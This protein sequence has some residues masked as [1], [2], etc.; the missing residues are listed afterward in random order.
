MKVLQFK[1][2]L[3]NFEIQK[4][5]LLDNLKVIINYKLDLEIVIFNLNF[6]EHRLSTVTNAQYI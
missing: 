2:Y 1:D 4:L 6:L 5:K 3:Q